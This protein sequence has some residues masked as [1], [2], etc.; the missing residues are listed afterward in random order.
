MAKVQANSATVNGLDRIY[1]YERP[2]G[3]VSTVLNPLATKTR[4]R[5]LCVGSQ[6]FLQLDTNQDGIFD[7]TQAPLTIATHN[8]AG[9]IGIVAGTIGSSAAQLDNFAAFDAVL[10]QTGIG[11]SGESRPKIGTKYGMALTTQATT[12]TPFLCAMSLTNGGT[13]NGNLGGIPIGGGRSIPLGVDP[14]LDLSLA[15]GG[16]LG[17]NG[18]TDAAGVGNPKVAIPNLQSLIGVGVHVAAVTAGGSGIANISNN[19]YVVFGQ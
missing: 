7:T 17:L 6:A 8:A 4:I 16:V 1:N 10:T 3:A 12:I 9:E 19:H 15:L 13:M 18:I 14:L 11:T 2:G 5:M